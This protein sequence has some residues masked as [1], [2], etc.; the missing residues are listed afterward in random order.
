MSL[1]EVWCDRRQ[2]L[3]I[4][5]VSAASLID[6]FPKVLNLKSI[7]RSAPTASKALGVAVNVSMFMS[8]S[9]AWH[10]YSDDPDCGERASAHRDEFR[11]FR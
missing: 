11:Q 1:D 6:T 5:A 7:D 10:L 9:C 3:P 4:A 2:F 8:F